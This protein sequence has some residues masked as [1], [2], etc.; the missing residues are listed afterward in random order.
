MLKLLASKMYPINWSWHKRIIS[1][2]VVDDVE[3]IVGRIFGVD[4][5]MEF[6]PH[7]FLQYMSILERFLTI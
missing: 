1:Y 6:F 7:V 2:Q 3:A 5:L 4:F